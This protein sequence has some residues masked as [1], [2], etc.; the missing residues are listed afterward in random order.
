[1]QSKYNR[2]KK[3]GRLCFLL[4]LSWC[5]HF[6]SKWNM[7][8]KK[9]QN[10]R[11]HTETSSM[12]H[13]NI[14]FYR[15]SGF[16]YTKI[17]PIDTIAAIKT[18]IKTLISSLTHSYAFCAFL[19]FHINMLKRTKNISVSHSNWG[20]N[21]IQLQPN[22]LKWPDICLEYIWVIQTIFILVL[23]IV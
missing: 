3:N 16:T 4:S 5:F 14:D 21:D 9:R 15:V 20:M 10:N 22:R 1:M 12:C 6:R 23:I 18:T 19:L 11:N 13:K 7:C 8:G 17:M 2:L